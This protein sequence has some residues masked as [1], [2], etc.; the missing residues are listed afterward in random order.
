LK[1]LFLTLSISRVK[2]FVNDSK[3]FVVYKIQ[4]FH[5]LLGKAFENL[6]GKAF[7]NL[8]DKAFENLL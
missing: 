6:L 2:P 3:R 4:G 7:E 5:N 8:L 1:I